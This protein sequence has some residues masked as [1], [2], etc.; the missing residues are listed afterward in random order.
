M[1]RSS[2]AEIERA[3]SPSTATRCSAAS[4]RKRA[5]RSWSSRRARS[6]SAHLRSHTS[7]ATDSIV[8]AIVAMNACR[9]SRAALALATAKG[10]WPWSVPA[11]AIAHSATTAVLAMRGP[12]RSGA[13]RSG[14]MHRKAIGARCMADGTIPP[15]TASPTAITAVTAPMASAARRR[16]TAR[17][18]RSLQRTKSGAT[19]TA[20]AASPSHQ[21]IQIDP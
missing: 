17:P 10:P 4:A 14:G 3:I 20:P 12:K 15:K 16:S 11:T 5:A 8:T 9:S 13:Q 18:R 1:S 6:S 2:V 19:R 21:V 7:A